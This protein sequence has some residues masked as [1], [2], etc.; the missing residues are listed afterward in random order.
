MTSLIVD[1]RSGVERLRARQ[2]RRWMIVGGCLILIGADLLF[3]WATGDLPRNL[4]HLPPD[5]AD[6]MATG[7]LVGAAICLF[8][9]LRMECDEHDI[10]ARRVGAQV[11]FT[12]FVIAYP[13]WALFA[14]GRLLPPVNMTALWAS[15]VGLYLATFLWRKYR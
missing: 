3:M 11:A 13:V 12:T 4:T 1:E 14:I 9:I 7:M 5:L 2:R 6:G 8:R 15:A 10:Q